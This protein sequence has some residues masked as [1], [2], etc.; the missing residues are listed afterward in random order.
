MARPMPATPKTHHVTGRLQQSGLLAS[1]GC[2]MRAVVL[3][4]G[5]LQRRKPTA[6]SIRLTLILN[7][8]TC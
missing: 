4:S 7:E 1:N 5:Q 3:V 8:S 2:S 6:T